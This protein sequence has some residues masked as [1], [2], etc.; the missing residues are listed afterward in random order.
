LTEAL[1]VT[2]YGA[3][4]ASRR[5]TVTFTKLQYEWLQREAER[6]GITVSDL[7]RR[8][9]DATRERR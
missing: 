8:I 4:P 5:Q 2:T 1:I 7:V 6:L 3:M 9:V